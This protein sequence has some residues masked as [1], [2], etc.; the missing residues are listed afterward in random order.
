MFS[1]ARVFSSLITVNL[2]FFGL[3]TVKKFFTKR[4]FQIYKPGVTS[5][6]RV[7]VADKGVTFSCE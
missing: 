5:L 7:L 3:L 2:I 1:Q 6:H 4:T